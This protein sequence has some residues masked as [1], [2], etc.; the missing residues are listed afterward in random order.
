MRH[1]AAMEEAA[2][3]VSIILPTYN[4]A[5]LVCEAARSV[6]NQTFRRWELL[7]IDDGS[8]DATRQVLRGLADARI[9]IIEQEHTRNPALLRNLAAG[10]AKGD[11]L[12]FLDSDD[13]WL[14]EKL[15]VQLRALRAAPGCRWSYSDVHLI[16]AAG[17]EIPREGYP[18]WKTVGGSIL[19]PLLVH[20]AVIACPTVLCEASL[21]REAR[22]FDASLL[23]CEDYDLWLRF[24]ARSWA[25]AVPE[26]LT[27]VRLHS[28]SNTF[29]RVEVHECFAFLYDRLGRESDDR[30]IQSL[31]R[32]QSAYYLLRAVRYHL[33]A[34]RHA[35]AG[36]ALAAALRRNAWTLDAWRAL[37][38]A[39]RRRPEEALTG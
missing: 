23:F 16:D 9:Q 38:R 3:L 5:E 39:P 37:A 26:R 31:C 10:R 1:A 18:V 34:R 25:C 19:K 36:M 8:T 13:Q 24:A 35:A 29:G 28:E 33:S 15:D 6:L 27:R 32:R 22:G 21:F 20:E 12:A 30:E 14:P 7:I 2:P 4:R 11:Y 17:R